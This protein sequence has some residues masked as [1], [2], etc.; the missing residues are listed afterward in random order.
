MGVRVVSGVLGAALA[1]SSCGGAGKPACPTPSAIPVY[2]VPAAA[3]TRVEQP[4]TPSEASGFLDEVEQHLRRLWVAR[5]EAGWVNENFIT[6]DTEALAAA[7]EEAIAAY[8]GEAI[9]R[10]KRYR[11]IQEGLPADVARKLYLLSIAQTVPAPSD[12]KERAELAN[13]ETS[14][15]S[16]YGKGQYCPPAG[17]ALLE[18]RK[19][20]VPPL[21]SPRTGDK[22]GVCLHLDELSR[23]LRTSRKADRLLESWRGWHAV[24]APLKDRYV[25]YVVLA[26]EG[27]R[28]IGF[29]DVG[30]LWRAGY[31]MAPDAFEADIERLWTEVKPL[32]DELH[33]YV[34]ARLQAKYGKAEVADH[35]PIPAHLLGNM[36]AQE[37]NNIGDLVAPFPDEPPLDAGKKLK[38][39]HWDALKMVRQGERFFSGLGFAPLPETFWHRSL[40]TR[41]RDR[42]VVCH[43]SAWDVTWS[44]DLRIKM[45]IEQTEED[46]V[47]IH[48]ELGHLF[49][50]QRYVDLPVLFQQGANDGFHEAIGDTIALSVTPAYLKSI[51]LLDAVHAGE[52]ARINEQMKMALEKVAFLPFGLLIDKWRWDVFSGKVQPTDY[53]AAWWKLREKYQ[54][55]KAP[56]ARSSAD[57]DPGA[58]FHVAS[59]TPY[60]RY[61]LARIYQFQFHKALCDA[62]GFKGALDECS[63]ADNK[64]AGIKL[65]TMLSLG[66][67]KPWPDALESIGA[68]RRADARPLLEYFEPLAKWLTEQNKGQA[69]GW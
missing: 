46:L 64:V 40:F 47:T 9:K 19:A 17:S 16:S 37:W 28:E 39:E 51:G 1:A 54:G 45:C 50:F 21:S 23:V 43:A 8:V 33:C 10:S 59:S 15:T 22:P 58:K 56:V 32:Y 12:S 55:V 36:W 42:E 26:N 66:A 13:I 30:A 3:T 35:A 62:A 5:D 6:D 14:M 53:N 27:A 48:H 20:E 69:C 67:S 65:M 11:P 18:G 44:G 57:F 61:F 29:A 60:I 24:A 49:Y 7:G 38:S 52:R 2:G 68:G 41:P 25:R 31:D 34:R 4:P 63:I